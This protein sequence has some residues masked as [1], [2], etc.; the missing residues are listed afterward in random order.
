MLLI[1]SHETDDKNNVVKTNENSILDQ[2][3]IGKTPKKN[4]Q[5]CIDIF[6]KCITPIQDL[7]YDNNG[8][9]NDDSYIELSNKCLKKKND[10]VNDVRADK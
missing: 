9:M 5:D 8:V 7:Y 10:C 2:Y 3:N 6:N 1:E 4:Y